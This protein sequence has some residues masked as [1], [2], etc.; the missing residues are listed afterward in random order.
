MFDTGLQIRET[1]R[2]LEIR[3]H[4]QP[5]A[6]RCEI[7]GVFNGAL[8][9]KITAPPVDDAANRA[10]IGFLSGLLS[11]P[12]SGLRIL[13]GSRSRDK[14]LEIRGISPDEFRLRIAGQQVPGKT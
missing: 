12:K 10:I 1:G 11:L 8:K 3:L 9:V 4:V 13:A 2:G 6:R 14:V 7:A 5:R